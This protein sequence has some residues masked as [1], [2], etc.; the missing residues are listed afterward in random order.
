[1]KEKLSEVFDALQELD[2]KPTPHNVSIMKGVYSSLRE[3]YKELEETENARGTENGS[4]ANP[5]GRNPN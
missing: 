2:M 5:D 3:I 4:A 1:M